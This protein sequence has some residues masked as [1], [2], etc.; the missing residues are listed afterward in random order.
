MGKLS[1]IRV[2]LALGLLVAL[3]HAAWSALVWAGQAKGLLD[4]Y[5]RLHFLANPLQLEGFSLVTAGQ[6]IAFGFV[7]GLVVGVVFALLWNLLSIFARGKPA[8]KKTE[9]KPA[10]PAPAAAA[11]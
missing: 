8:E 6:L 1:I 3:V 9:A 10:A 7:S 5:F 4:H 11:H 2:G